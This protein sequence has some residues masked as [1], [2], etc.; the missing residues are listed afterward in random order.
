LT[1]FGERFTHVNESS[2]AMLRGS[3][4]LLALIVLAARWKRLGL[5]AAELRAVAVLA[6]I[7]LFALVLTP[8][9]ST[10]A[11]RL[12]YYAVPLQMIVLPRAARTISSA[13]KR[14]AAQAA[15]ALLCLGMFLAWMLLSPYRACLTPY[16]SYLAAP[17][18]IRTLD[19]QAHRRSQPCIVRRGSFAGLNGSTS[20]AAL[21]E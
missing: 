2:G 19:P 12:G 9:L 20:L 4:T 1:P 13:V 16:R 3:L 15:I 10:A 17:G 18:A 5:A 7:G 6:A 14:R 8:T 21:L 11:D